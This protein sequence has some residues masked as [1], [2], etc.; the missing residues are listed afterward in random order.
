MK[1]SA[2]KIP[3]HPAWQIDPASRQGV[4]GVEGD[5]KLIPAKTSD[6]QKVLNAYQ[7]HPIEHY[8]IA[9][10]EWVHNP[11]LDDLF[12]VNMRMLNKQAGN[13]KFE[14]TWAG[15]SQSSELAFRQSI[16]KTHEQLSAPYTDLS[17]PNVQ[18]LPLWHGT[19]DTTAQ[20]IFKSGYGI[21]TSNDPAFVTDPGF[22]GKG[23]YS[24][25]EA[26]YC[27]RAYASQYNSGGK[28]GAVLILNWVSSF[29][30]YPVIYKDMPFLYGRAGGQEQCDTHFVPIRSKDHP[31]T[32]NY[33]ACA[34]G[35]RA[36]YTEVVVFHNSQCLPRYRVKLQKRSI[37]ALLTLPSLDA[38]Q[39]GLK[40]W[41]LR[42]YKHVEAAFEEAAGLG[43]PL[44]FVRL[45][46]LSSGA[47]EII[48][49]NTEAAQKWAEHCR[50]V[51]PELAHY[52]APF[53]GNDKEAQF[54]VG[55]CYAEGLGVGA[56]KIKAAKYYWMASEQNHQDASYQLAECCNKGEGVKKNIDLALF[57]Y[58]KAAALGHTHANYKLAQMYS[59][60]FGIEPNLELAEKYKA[61]AMVGHHPAL[62]PRP[63]SP[64]LG[65]QYYE[66]GLVFQR[67][68]SAET[69]KEAAKLYQKAAELGHTRARSALGFFFL[70][71]RGG[72][73]P[74]LEKAHRFFKQS[75]EEGDPHAMVNLANQLR[76]GY[77]VPKD[78]V[79]AQ[80][81]KDKAQESMREKEK[82][83]K[84]GNSS[85]PKP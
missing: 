14:P 49:K 23:I 36:Q 77:G 52:A 30:I 55:W 65:R 53:G 69:D 80:H 84:Q 66:E 85:A 32:I 41:E 2:F 67:V 1:K 17:C 21:F 25:H 34:P 7:H 74:D 68:K 82:E 44:S 46:W 3:K 70:A 38:H 43:C 72:C 83:E 56:N 12:K 75:A 58:Q 57:Y 51:Y 18:L 59:M 16:A 19:S 13:K 78:E 62:T 63:I 27:F 4:L 79:A 15:K 50:R 73:A 28:N 60:G 48:E 11:D 76:K 81:W 8:D 22:F 10:I 47:S 31:N 45:H 54:L 20:F 6:V 33:N 26:E 9:S 29:Q 42:Q 37:A 5:F 64:P 39:A 35:E 24:A 40:M 71:G 61:A